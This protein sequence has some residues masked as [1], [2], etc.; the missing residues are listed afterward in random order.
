MSHRAAETLTKTER[1]LAP[2]M[3]PRG[4]VLS[5]KRFKMKYPILMNVKKLPYVFR[6]VSN[7]LSNVDH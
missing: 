6:A 4:P 1:M 3:I 2:K 7:K 5:L